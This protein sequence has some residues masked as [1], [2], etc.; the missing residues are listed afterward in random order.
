MADSYPDLGRLWVCFIDYGGY[1]G[2]AIK[3]TL[4]GKKEIAVGAGRSRSDCAI[5]HVDPG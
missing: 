4:Q 3:A 2:E 5:L 1:N